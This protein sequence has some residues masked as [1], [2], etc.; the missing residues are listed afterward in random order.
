MICRYGI[1]SN[2]FF[3]IGISKKIIIKRIKL[4]I[5]I[6]E[7]VKF[8]SKRRMSISVFFGTTVAMLIL[9]NQSVKKSDSDR[10]M[11]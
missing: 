7:F 10:R 9:D 11:S 3:L 5:K 1:D 2:L 6:I 4:S 8:K